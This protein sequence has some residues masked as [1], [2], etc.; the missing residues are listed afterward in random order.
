MAQNLTT[1]FI[2]Y[3]NMAQAIAQGLV[4]AGV[5]AGGQMVACAAHYDKLRSHHCRSSAC[6][7]CT[8]RCEVVAAA[9]VVIIAIK[10]YQIDAVVKPHRQT[11]SPSTGEIVVLHRRRL[12][13]REV[14]GPVHHRRRR[15][16]RLF[17][18]SI[19]SARFRTRRWPSARACSS[20]RSDNTLTDDADRGLRVSCSARFQPHRARRHRTHD[21]RHGGG[22]L[23]TRLHRHVH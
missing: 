6:A 12:E 16:R 1:G 14:P 21:H 7:R 5:V 15:I 20:P 22:R 13:S 11:N 18:A 17:G 9:D 19:S 8:M 2:G 10:P 23:R 3:G 4:D